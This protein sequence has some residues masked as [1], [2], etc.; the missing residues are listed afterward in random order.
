MSLL[1]HELRERLNGRWDWWPPRLRA[2]VRPTIRLAGFSDARARLRVAAHESSHA[3]VA[4]GGGI[5][6]VVATCGYG[7]EERPNLWG[8]VHTRSR[9]RDDRPLADRA[10]AD[11][12]VRLAGVESDRAFFDITSDTVTEDEEVACRV[13]FFIGPSDQLDTIIKAGREAALAYLRSNWIALARL[14]SVLDERSELTGDEIRTIIGPLPPL[15]P[16]PLSKGERALRDEVVRRI[17]AHRAAERRAEDARERRIA[18]LAERIREHRRQ[19]QRITEL[20]PH[21]E[22]FVLRDGSRAEQI[23]LLDGLPL[24]ARY[25][26]GY[27]SM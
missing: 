25:D 4:V 3:L 17:R 2:P 7:S 1:D 16:R 20:A 15:P 26:G 27:C 6:V 14:T 10:W 5:D 11:L 19:E 18:A 23:T 21:P 8:H 24:Y 9:P 22:T 13:A 12:L